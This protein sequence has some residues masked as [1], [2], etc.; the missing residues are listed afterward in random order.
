MEAQWN[1]LQRDVVSVTR[2]EGEMGIGI[3]IALMVS[4]VSGGVLAYLYGSRV[5]D[6]VRHDAEVLH[7]ETVMR[8]KDALTEIQARVDRLE[9]SGNQAWTDAKQTA[10]A[11]EKKL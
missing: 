1:R 11:V 2:K 4:F 7:H 8:I 6:T 10:A 3:G 9:A 5:V